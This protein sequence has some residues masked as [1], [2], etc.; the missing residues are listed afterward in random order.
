MPLNIDHA[1]IKE[2]E[3][4]T[5]HEIADAPV[6]AI[7]GISKKTAESF[8]KPRGIHTVRDLANFKY[9]RWAQG[10]IALADRES[11]PDPEPVEAPAEEAG[12]E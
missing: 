4:K 10:I 1:V 9:V 3:D 5:L 12:E 7:E 6:W 11:L 8:F 2:F